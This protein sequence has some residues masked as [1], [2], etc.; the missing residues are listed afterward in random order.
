ML[1]I[2]QYN[3]ISTRETS[4]KDAASVRTLHDL[5]NGINAFKTNVPLILTSLVDYDPFSYSNSDGAESDFSEHFGKY[6]IPPGF[7]YIYFRIE[8]ALDGASAANMSWYV[9]A[10]VIKQA[11]RLLPVGSTPVDNGVAARVG[12][13][14]TSTSYSATLLSLKIEPILTGVRQVIIYLSHYSASPGTAATAYIRSFLAAAGG[15]LQ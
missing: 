15:V 4:A 14:T 10:S 8:H 6:Y 1:E 9:Y 13:T 2:N 5:A 3:P 12:F 7:S 11:N